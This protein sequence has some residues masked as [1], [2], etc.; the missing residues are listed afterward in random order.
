MSATHAGKSKDPP[1]APLAGSGQAVAVKR[2]GAKP[3][4][5]GDPVSR[6][7]R[8]VAAAILEVLAGVRTPT[9]AASTLGVSPPRYYLWEQRALDGLVR[10]CEPRPKGKAASERR[11]I[12]ILEKEVARLRQECVRQQSLARASQRAMTMP[13]PPATVPKGNGKPP[14]K[15]GG[16]SAG[17][18]QRKRRPVARALQAVAVLQAAPEAETAADS[19]SA[20]GEE[21][22]QRMVMDR[23]L[24]LVAPPGAAV[25]ET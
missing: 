13:L 2:R 24:P 6:D 15:S 7:A 16:D 11:Q 18:R 23:L 9:E 8:R 17:K 3:L 4:R 10:A 25:M 5:K 21:M 19:S 1:A 20:K 22:V 14:V 12:A